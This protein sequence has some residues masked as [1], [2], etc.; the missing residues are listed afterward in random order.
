MIIRRGAEVVAMLLIAG[1]G[2][3][4]QAALAVNPSSADANA[5]AFVEQIIAYERGG[6]GTGDIAFLAFFTPELREL[7]E[8]DRK[9]AGDQDAP[10]LDGDPFC[11]CQDNE[12]LVMRIIWTMRKEDTATALIRNHFKGSPDPDHDVTMRLRITNA[13]WRVDDITTHEQ[14]SLRAGLRDALQRR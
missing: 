8:A 5:R 3:A 10:Y 4:S 13:G 12:E 9:A 11:D 1:S 14:P 2:V 6:G 7:I